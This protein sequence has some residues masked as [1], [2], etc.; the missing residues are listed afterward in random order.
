MEKKNRLASNRLVDGT[1]APWSSR[2]TY[3][4]VSRRRNKQVYGTKNGTKG[5]AGLRERSV[6]GGRE[7]FSSVDGGIK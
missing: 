2:S 1:P 4:V 6:V 5:K 3:D 7:E